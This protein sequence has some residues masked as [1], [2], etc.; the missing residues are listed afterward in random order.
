M[1]E[2]FNN[3]YGII[4]VEVKMDVCLNDFYRRHV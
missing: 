1:E 3:R 2:D 4:V